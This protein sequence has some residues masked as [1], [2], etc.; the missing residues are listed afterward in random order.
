M[1]S[2]PVVPMHFLNIFAAEISIETT[3]TKAGPTAH[4]GNGAKAPDE[5]GA[6]TDADEDC[7][8]TVPDRV[9]STNIFNILRK[10]RRK[11]RFRADGTSASREAS[12]RE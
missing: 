12:R 10:A 4:W 6:A 9:A 11:I 2:D 1:N 5:P 3:R 8:R 7:A